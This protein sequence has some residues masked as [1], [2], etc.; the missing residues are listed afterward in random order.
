MPKSV[1]VVDDDPDAAESLA[2]LLNLTGHRAR[3][4]GD[5]LKALEAVRSSL[6]EVVLIDIGL[7]GM[8]GYELAERLRDE[9]DHLPIVLVALTG[10]CQDND[11]ER[12]LKS[13]FNVHLAKPAAWEDVER[14]MASATTMPPHTA[15][16]GRM[17]WPTS[18]VHLE[19]AHRWQL[20]QRWSG[21][22]PVPENC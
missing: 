5:G 16:S 10:Y 20:L 8:N 14:A 11:R 17:H 21:A 9:F 22:D 3:T 7:P 2:M 13:G 12:A 1:L 6:P 15:S 18:Q 4:A 19:N